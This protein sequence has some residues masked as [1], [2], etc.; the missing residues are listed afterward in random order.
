MTHRHVLSTA[1][2]HTRWLVMAAAV[3]FGGAVQPA[4]AQERSEKQQHLMETLEQLEHGMAA[5]E[6]LGRLEEMEMLQRVANDVRRD[7][8]R[9]RP[10]EGRRANRELEIVAM[11][12]EALE[13]SLP[14]LREGERMEAVEMVERAIQAREMMLEGRRDREAR[15]VR[16]HAPNRGQIREL[17]GLS[18][19]LYQ[20]FGMHDRAENLAGLMRELWPVRDRDARRRVRGGRH[21]EAAVHQVEVM[22]MALPALLEAGKH[23]AADLLERA[24]RAREVVLEGRADEEAHAIRERSPSLGQQVELLQFSAG[25]WREFG[26]EEKAQVIS[27]LAQRM[28]ADR[29]REG[30]RDRPEANPLE[31]RVNTLEEQLAELLR[32]LDA[33]RDELGSGAR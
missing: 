33:L 28:W 12:I 16:E 14:A 8:D 11:Q 10:A 31:R 13:L 30:E 6:R 2:S 19:E 7:L 15:M 23:D 22:R 9:E 26:H 20:E 17:M 18:I 1:A 5:L 21:H 29:P 25:L 4:T 3:A 27:E 24:V 32:T